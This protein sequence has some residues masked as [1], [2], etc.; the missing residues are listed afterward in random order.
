MFPPKASSGITVCSAIWRS[1]RSSRRSCS[2]LRHK[3]K[4]G[5]PKK[6]WKYIL[7]KDTRLF[8]HLRAGILNNTMNLPGK[9]GEKDG[10]PLRRISFH[11]KWSDSTSR[12]PCC[13]CERLVRTMR[14]YEVWENVAFFESKSKCFFRVDQSVSLLTITGCRQPQAD[15]ETII[16]PHAKPKAFVG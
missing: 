5:P 7:R 11:R 1:S 14:W 9:G 3:G 2:P 8:H 4:S 12:N 13:I 16:K 15:S 10:S 6:L